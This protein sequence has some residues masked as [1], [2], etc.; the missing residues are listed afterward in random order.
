[1]WGLERRPEGEREDAGRFPF[2]L[3]S[4]SRIL[5]CG[6]EGIK[7]LLSNWRPNGYHVIVHNGLIT[8]QGL[9]G[10]RILLP[11]VLCGFSSLEK[12]IAIEQVEQCWLKA[13]FPGS[14]KSLI[15]ASGGG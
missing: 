12:V 5:V 9:T 14:V 8:H 6:G 13:P 10:S 1:M 15:W 4:F 3:L 7:L 11:T 2:V